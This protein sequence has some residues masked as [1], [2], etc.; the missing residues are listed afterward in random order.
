MVDLSKFTSNKK[1]LSKVVTTNFV[2]KF[3]ALYNLLSDYF[4][5]L[6][7]NFVSNILIQKKKKPFL[8]NIIMWLRYK[9]VINIKS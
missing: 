9:Q 5:F 7:I 2:A 3:C 6:R 8:S 1:I 4:I